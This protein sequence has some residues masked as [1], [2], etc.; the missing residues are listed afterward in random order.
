MSFWDGTRWVPEVAPGRSPKPTPW[1]D[2][3]ATI[4]MILVIMAFALPFVATSATTAPTIAASPSSGVAGTSVTVVGANFP[5]KTRLQLTWDG[6]AAAMPSAIVNNRGV[7]K[8]RVRVP[9]GH[10]GPHVLAA[11]PVVAASVATAGDTSGGGSIASSVF[12]LADPASATATPNATPKPTQASTPVPTPVVMPTPTPTVA[13][14][15]TPG[16]TPNATAKPTAVATPTATPTP[17]AASVATPGATPSATAEPTAAATPT[18]APT[19]PTDPTTPPTVVPTPAPTPVP[20]PSLKVVGLTPTVTATQFVAAVRDNTTDVI[21]LAGGIYHPG[22]ITLN[23]DRTRPLIIRPK[24]GASAVFAG[25]SGSAFHIGS[26]GV[27]GGITLEGLVFDGYSIG[28]TGIVWLGNCHDITV[29]DM[30]VRN[31]TGPAGYS[32]ALYVS[33]NGG[34]SARN[35]VANHWTVDGGARTLGG[36]QIGN[37]SGPDNNGVSAHGWRVTN[38]SYAIYSAAGA[39]GVDIS[40]WT[41]DSSGLTTFADLS[42]VLVNTSGTIRNVHATNSGGPE[43]DRPMVDAGGNTW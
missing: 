35:V 12:S 22:L 8:V 20:S 38:A 14:D 32:W 30:V 25:G 40:D 11:W 26:G 37:S 1:R 23:V 28:D 29:N 19:P 42:V 9:S 31:S 34:V 7:F 4:T 6:S 24:A 41:I 17:T 21:E 18:A 36:L 2:S 16:A 5:N 13:S 39:A 15:A 10:V 27:A 33:T 3:A 43:I